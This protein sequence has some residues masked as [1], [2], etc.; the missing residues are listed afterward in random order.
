MTIKMTEFLSFDNFVHNEAYYDCAFMIFG[1]LD[2]KNVYLDTK[3]VVLSV[4]EA[5]I[6]ISEISWRPF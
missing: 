2:L 5:E 4:L 3:I 1:F 6:L